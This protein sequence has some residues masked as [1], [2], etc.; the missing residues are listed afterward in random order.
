MLRDR[1]LHLACNECRLSSFQSTPPLREKERYAISELREWDR[2]FDLLNHLIDATLYWAHSYRGSPSAWNARIYCQRKV[3]LPLCALLRERDIARAEHKIPIVLVV[4]EAKPFLV[5]AELITV[6]TVGYWYSTLFSVHRH[7][8]VLQRP[9][10]SDVPRLRC[11]ITKT[12]GHARRPRFCSVA[13]QADYFE[14]H[15]LTHW[16]HQRTCRAYQVNS[17]ST[18]LTLN[19][20]QCSPIKNLHCTLI[21]INFH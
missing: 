20:R 2:T 4:T 3:K 8:A 18:K 17:T 9:R 1:E 19:H 6:P 5:C 13:R 16:T 21:S 7:T 14:G 11:I 12:S 15:V 10:Y